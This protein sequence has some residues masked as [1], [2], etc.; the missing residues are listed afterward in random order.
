MKRRMRGYS[1][2]AAQRRSPAGGLTL[3]VYIRQGPSSTPIYSLSLAQSTIDGENLACNEIRRS[4]EI[5][6]R[7]GNFGGSP[8]APRRSVLDHALA[9][10]VDVFERNHAGSDGI[11][12]DFGSEGLGERAGEHDDASFGS[13]VVGV[14]R[15]GTDA[16]QRT[17][18]DDAPIALPLHEARGLLAAEEDRLQVNGVDE[19]PIPLGDVE[20]VEAGEARGVVVQAIEGPQA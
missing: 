18:V 10:L 20:R 11:H 14:L 15:P 9:A 19:V 16:A 1:A 3:R 5:H 12:G 17:D 2:H 4:E 13:A 7:I 8:A 6:H